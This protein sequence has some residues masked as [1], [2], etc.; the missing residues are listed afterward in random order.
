MEQKNPY[1]QSVSNALQSSLAGQ[2]ASGYAV[3]GTNLPGNVANTLTTGTINWS[4]PYPYPNPSYPATYTYPY[5]IPTYTPPLPEA[6]RLAIEILNSKCSPALRKKAEVIL[7][8]G[9]QS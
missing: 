3:S 7:A 1:L 4:P 2:Q 6:Y 5:H 8:K 9:L